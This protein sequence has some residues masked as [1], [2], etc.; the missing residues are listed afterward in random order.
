MMSVAELSLVA[1]SNDTPVCAMLFVHDGVKQHTS[2]VQLPPT[3]A[4][5]AGLL[6]STLS[7]SPLQSK[8]AP[9]WS[10]SA[11]FGMTQHVSAVQTA[12]THAVV[13]AFV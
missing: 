9:A 10:V 5:P 3:Q 1:Q 8:A 4:V 7:A 6:R 12:P 11:Q 13:D 2:D